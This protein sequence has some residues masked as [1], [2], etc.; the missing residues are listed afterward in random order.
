MA[1]AEK[2]LQ[3]ESILKKRK[4]TMKFAW[5]KYFF[6]LRNTTLSFYTSK[7]ADETCLRGKY[8]IHLVQSVREVNATA[9]NYT[10]EIVMKN[11]KRKLLSADSAELRKIWIEYLWKSMQLPFPG[12]KNSSCTWHD[13]PSLE[14]RAEADELNKSDSR[15]ELDDSTY[16]QLSSSSDA[17]VE[18]QEFESCDSEEETNIYDYPKSK[19]EGECTKTCFEEESNEEPEHFDPYDIPNTE[20]TLIMTKS[21]EK[22]NEEPEHF[23]LYDIP[24]PENILFMTKSEE[25]SNEEPEHIDL[26]D[27]PNPENTLIMTKSKEESNGGP[28]HFDLYYIPNPA[29]IVIMTQFGEDTEDTGE[30]STDSDSGPL[31]ELQGVSNV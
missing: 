30:Q 20:N 3:F 28:E 29:N 8:Y 23:D 15:N 14:Q 13:L 4:D 12:R 5:S 18:E 7:E 31:D 10:F 21:E 22:S 11:G 19:S 2:E 9:S 16:D 6:R 1:A 27:S 25:K 24:N 17:L 26:Y